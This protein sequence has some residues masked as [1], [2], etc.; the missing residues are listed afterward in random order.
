M[1]ERENQKK[2]V[3]FRKSLALKKAIFENEDLD[4]KEGF[5]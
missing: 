2:H 5:N 1:N 4:W 3:G